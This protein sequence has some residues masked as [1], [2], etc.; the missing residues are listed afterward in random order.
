MATSPTLA[1]GMAVFSLLCLTP[2]SG[3]QVERPDP[4][5]QLEPWDGGQAVSAR[6]LVT[7]SPEH[8]R[9]ALLSDLGLVVQR[10]LP[11]GITWVS[12]PSARELA[13][14]V[15]DLAGRQEVLAV[16]PDLT[17]TAT[18]TPSD[19][20]WPQQWG[21]LLVGVANA[22]D[23]ETGAP[24]T[25]IA[26]LDSGADL[27]HPDLQPQIAWG[28]DTFSGDDT[29]SDL[30]GHGSHCAGIASAAGDDGVGVAGAAGLC[31]LA[32][33]RC[34]N[35]TFPTSSLLLALDDAVTR[36]A[37]VL[38]LSWGSYGS[39]PALRQGIL[40]AVDAGCVVVAA[41]GNDGISSS[42]YPAA[43]PEVL[44][45]ASSDPFDGRSAFSNYG[46]WVELTA[47]G[48]SILST[49]K[50]GGWTSMSGT[51]M[52]CP[53][54]AGVAGLLYAR[55]GGE[56]SVEHADLVW[57]ALTGS[58]A[59]VGSWVVHGRLDPTAAVALLD[60]SSPP[61]VAGLAAA[62]AAAEGHEL[63]LDLRGPGGSP[64]ALLMAPLGT[65]ASVKGMELLLTAQLLVLGSLPAEGQL[66]L[67]TDVPASVVGATA[68]WQLLV[69]APS[70][71]L[72][73]S[74]VLSTTFTP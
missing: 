32:I 57:D 72:A 37:R 58:A 67:A 13:S 41:A 33:Y 69:Q 10:E 44:A 52:A 3:A 54:V 27:D 50:T 21:P 7:F 61:P 20:K 46:A 45:V 53:L 55:L 35:G 6:A 36:G 14:L 5:I 42:F 64:A 56:R 25:V 60:T 59:P 48:Q 2:S 38:S 30:D 26:V 47:P 62:D 71:G 16:Q 17:S 65:T 34:G 9:S 39:N 49:W 15:D 4:P 51:S 19:P 1:I 23:L 31:R 73:A 28:L 24:G 74:E 29:P 11:H 8:D 63:T 18:G 12:D 68:W 43:W 22:W 70:G 40:A 66:S